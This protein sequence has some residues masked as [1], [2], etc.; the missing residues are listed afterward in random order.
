MLD[1]SKISEEEVKWARGSHLSLLLFY[2]LVIIL[3]SKS[4]AFSFPIAMLAVLLFPILILFTKGRKSGFVA[5]HA[6]E[7]IFLQLVG[8]MLSYGVHLLWPGAETVNRLM[9]VLSFSGISLYHFGAVVA[10]SI[11]STYKKIISFPFS[12]FKKGKIPKD[13]FEQ[14]MDELKSLENVDKVTA[15]LLQET[16]KIGKEKVSQIDSLLP[17]IKEEAVKNHVVEIREW[18]VKIFENF[19]KDPADI[20][21]SR[22]FLTYYLDTTVKI[23]RKYIELSDQKVISPELQESLSRVDGLLVEVKKAFSNHYDKLLLNDK[24][25]LDAEITVM[26]KTIKLEGL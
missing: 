6:K 21:V 2:P 10:G 19:A 8:A 11:K 15:Q 12:I 14:S 13:S 20:K 18:I 22:Q 4:V 9:Q 16:L 1:E 23:I 26:E 3:L 7:A 24:M 5:I 17:R 25:D